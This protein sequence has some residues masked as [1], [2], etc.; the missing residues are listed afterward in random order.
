MMI[1]NR[2]KHKLTYFSQGDLDEFDG[3][4]PFLSISEN[5]QELQPDYIRLVLK[6]R[7]IRS[8]FSRSSVSQDQME[9]IC[10]EKKI[11]F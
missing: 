6:I 3:T 9:I 8:F 11:K 7:E 4:E 2:F 10:T 1:M 5:I